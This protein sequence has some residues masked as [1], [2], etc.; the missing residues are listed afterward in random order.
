MTIK[1]IPDLIFE[2]EDMVII[3]KPAGL[4]SIP[5][6]FDLNKPNAHQILT[7][8]GKTV[9]TVHR[10]DKDTS[11]LL[12]FAKNSQT[13]RSLSLLF[14]EQK[15]QK[16]YL[17]IVHGKPPFEEGS[18]N[19]PIA[20]SSAGDGRM[21]IHPK[22]K[23][24]ETLFKLSH[25]WKKFSQIECKPLTGRTHQIRVHLASIHCPIVADPIYSLKP[26]LK[27]DDIKNYVRKGKFEETNPDL[28]ARTA[29]HAHS[30]KF[31]LNGQSLYF[32]CPLPKDMKAV[33]NQMNK[34]Q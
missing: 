21:I 12:I 13:H 4:L 22:G 3:D 20:H 5:D 7:Q 19:S 6:R 31:E 26:N 25:A 18:I 14:E 28:I 10:I 27:I 15:I 1:K 29:L 11:G 23:P 2:N 30:L 9:F 33:I 32:E 24:S 8:Q 17:A 16:T 34:W